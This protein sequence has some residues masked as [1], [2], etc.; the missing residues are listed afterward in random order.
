MVSNSQDHWDQHLQAVVDEDQDIH[1]SEEN[2][3]RLTRGVSDN[4]YELV[5]GQ[6]IQ[7]S[8]QSPVCWVSRR[9]PD[10]PVPICQ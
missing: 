10:H 4:D 9:N 6:D 8:D 7:R 5:F 3:L 1:Y 2:S